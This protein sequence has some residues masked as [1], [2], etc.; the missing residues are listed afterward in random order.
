MLA[1]ARAP[2]IVR[3]TAQPQK[4]RR[5][6]IKAADI[7]LAIDQASL[8]CFNFEDTVECRLAWEKVEELSST[9]HDQWMGD[10]RIH[11]RDFEAS[12]DEARRRARSEREYDV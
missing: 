1:V 12:I 4:P 5:N 9:Y 3:A 2:V 11:R 10:A 7:K 8:I 6:K